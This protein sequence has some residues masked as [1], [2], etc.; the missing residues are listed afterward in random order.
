MQEVITKYELNDPFT[1]MA[2]LLFVAIIVI[3]WY[4][5]YKINKLIKNQN[6]LSSST[7]EKFQMA[8]KKEEETRNLEIIKNLQKI[9]DHLSVSKSF[10][11]EFHDK[12]E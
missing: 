5:A 4:G 12:D 10:T 11:V 9:V 6:L 3:L 7:L 1:L 8:Q 2:I